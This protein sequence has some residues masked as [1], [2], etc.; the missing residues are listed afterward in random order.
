MSA[1]T[2]G[3]STVPVL[4]VGGGE[5]SV[6]EGNPIR[7]RHI[8]RE[9]EG[10]LELGMP[11]HALRALEKLGPRSAVSAN[12]LFLWG[13]T[14][15]SLGRFQEAIEPLDRAAAV[16]P[17]NIQVWL[18]LGWCHKRTSRLDLAIRDLEVALRSEPTAA[19]VHYNLACYLSLAGQRDR[20]I[21]ALAKA[22]AID[23]DFRLLVDSEPDFDPIRSD[24]EFQA[25][26]SVV[27]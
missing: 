25:L 6:A 27:V 4:A 15:R 21:T 8:E 17:D 26:V 18:A 2:M 20:A 10:Y 5:G 3:G 14:L 24:P 12:G 7:I 16:D 9:A 22:L 13:E 1:A 23:A 19:L 11:D